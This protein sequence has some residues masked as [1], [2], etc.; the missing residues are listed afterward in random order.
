MRSAEVL[1]LEAYD[2]FGTTPSAVGL[3][4]LVLV[5]LAASLRYVLAALRATIALARVDAA[6]A[7]VEPRLDRECVVSGVV[8]L[9]EDDRG[10]GPPVRLD[11]RQHRAGVS[12]R[13][14]QR[15]ASWIGGL[16]RPVV[17]PFVLRLPSGAALRVEP[18]SDVRFADALDDGADVSKTE[19]VRS[20]V[21]EPGEVAHVLG[22]VEQRPVP[23]GG[24]RGGA[25]ALVLSAPRAGP[26]LI[27]SEEQL[28]VTFRGK[29]SAALG[30]LAPVLLALAFV[31]GVIGLDFA[32]LVARGNVVEAPVERVEIERY[33]RKGAARENY[34]L[35]ARD[36]TSRAELR[37][38]IEAAP[39]Q[40]LAATGSERDGSTE[41]EP[42]KS[43]PF[44]LDPHAPG[45]RH[46]LGR[47]RFIAVMDLFIG[48]LVTGCAL[49]G[50]EALRA[51][52]RPWYER[53]TI[54]ER[55]VVD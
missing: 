38:R 42:G 9:A 33:T 4:L 26:M 14:G 10:A 17:R 6:A 29:R 24:Y 36:P 1:E 3:A 48:L 20:A 21:L 16:G 12:R 2:A 40:A 51:R 52:G 43:A 25:S 19:R 46:S 55:T 31:V 15:I 45:A 8:E 5:L 39:Y 23:G 27:S 18:G 44:V 7:G 47:V 49:L 28:R 37:A 54:E 30:A 13:G 50:A 22:R 35:V 41:V 53:D 11:V 32:L 34:Y